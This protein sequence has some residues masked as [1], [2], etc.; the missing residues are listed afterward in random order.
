[1]VQVLGIILTE[2]SMRLVAAMHAKKLSSSDKTL[3]GFRSA[4]EESVV[5]SPGQRMPD[6]MQCTVGT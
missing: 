5:R 1:M 2:R 3:A 6:D 4:Q